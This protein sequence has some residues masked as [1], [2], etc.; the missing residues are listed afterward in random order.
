MFKAGKYFAF[1]NKFYIG[2]TRVQEVKV[3]AEEADCVGFSL[4][5]DESHSCSRASLDR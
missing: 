4:V 5:G 2:D 3:E 1:I